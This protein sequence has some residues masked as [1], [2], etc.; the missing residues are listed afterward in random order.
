MTGAGLYLPRPV[1]SSY[2]QVLYAALM[3]WLPSCNHEPA[4]DSPPRKYD[5]QVGK[6]QYSVCKLCEKPIVLFSDDGR[7]MQSTTT[8]HP[9]LSQAAE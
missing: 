5:G 6:Q 9:Y 2:I 1:L 7:W 8:N 4:A 3:A